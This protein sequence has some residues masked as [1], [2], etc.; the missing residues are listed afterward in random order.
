MHGA[1]PVAYLAGP[2]GFSEVGRLWH[3]SVLIPMVQAAGFDIRDPWVLTPQEIIDPILALPYGPERKA[4]WSAA[5]VLIGANNAKGI[6]ESHVIIA[7]LDG[8]DVD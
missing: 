2:L 7:V 6:E 8:V 1:K 3:H 5:N 4:R